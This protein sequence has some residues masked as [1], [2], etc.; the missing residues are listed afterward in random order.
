MFYTYVSG[1]SSFRMISFTRE[2]TFPEIL[3]MGS[4]TEHMDIIIIGI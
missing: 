3:V 4:L 2:K 1:L